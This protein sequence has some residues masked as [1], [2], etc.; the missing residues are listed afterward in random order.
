MRKRVLTGSLA[1]FV[2][3]A[4]LGALPSTASAV[5]TRFDYTGAFTSYTVQTTGT[6]Q[7]FGFGAQGGARPGA[8]GGLGAESAGDIALTAGQVLT[9]AVGGAGGNAPA[10]GRAGGGG[11]G[12]FVALS[13]VALFIAGGGGGAGQPIDNGQ[14]G[15][16]AG[17]SGADG[18]NQSD[19]NFLGAG[20]TNGAGG[21]ANGIASG[22]GGGGGFL[23]D[24]GSNTAGGGGGASFANGLGGGLSVSFGGAGGFGGGGGAAF[25]GSGGG[26]GYSGGGGS[27]G[28]NGG[29]G[30]S[31]NVGLV[32]AD[33]LLL[34]SVNAGNG[35][36]TLE[37]L[38]VAPVPEPSTWALSV[39]GLIGLAAARRKT[40][41]P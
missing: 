9:I 14:S 29:G 21:S 37:L 40:R 4:V 22:G 6:Y 1:C 38:P 24:G 41:Q 11:G 8:A 26:G 3:A 39:I 12:T 2:Q 25:F 31:Y 19:A 18:A 33:R 13:G 23:T 35:Y 20:G 10:F 5:P 16:Q 7:I 27:G 15:G 32:N 36:L 34:G 28:G 17:T 30:G